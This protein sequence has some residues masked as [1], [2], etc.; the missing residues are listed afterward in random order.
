MIAQ[1]HGY[2]WRFQMDWDNIRIFLSVARAGQF[3]AA[4]SQLRIDN[5]TVGRRINALEK[6]LGVRLFDR[7][8]TGSVLTA[9][10]DRLYKTAEEVEAQ[11]L[12]AQGDL[13][14]SDVELSGAVRIA[15][16]DGFT[17]LF[18]CSRL[19]HLKAKYP[20]LTVQLVPMSRTFSL[21]KR[22]AD[23]AITI[24]RPDE[25]RLAVRKL[26]DYS[27][28]LYA[29]KA[30]L[31]EHGSPQRLEDLQRH[32]VVTYVQ[33][34]I[35]ADQL[36][37]MPELY[38]PTYSRLECS[39]AVGQLEAVRGGAGIGILHDYAAQRDEKLQIVLPGTEFERSY[40]IVTHLDMR[41]LSR[42]RAI[43]EFILAEV[44]AQKSIFRTRSDVQ[45]RN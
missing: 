30:Y 6:S 23:V 41:E 22:E 19:G 37:F 25:G 1:P 12:R 31:A 38:G 33:D 18:L 16:P 32:C 24:E 40:W 2:E 29:A 28:H 8:T 20:S 26:I 10:G 36:N 5:G 43:S 15:A 9:A 21:S 13:S 3:S 42:V 4:A 45:Q 7:Q 27:L 39:T 34:L 14:Q 35:F 11:L 44:K 17:T